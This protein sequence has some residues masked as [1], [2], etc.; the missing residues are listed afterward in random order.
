[1]N[2]PKDMKDRKALHMTARNVG[3]FQIPKGRIGDLAPWISQSA[4]RTSMSNPITTGA[5]TEADGHP[6]RGAWLYNADHQKSSNGLGYAGS[7]ERE[8]EQ[9]E[10][11]DAKECTEPIDIA[12][13]AESD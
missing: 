12:P 3:A 11:G 6:A 13:K 8:I 2:I 4:K 10:S 5:M 9:N 1:M 7:L